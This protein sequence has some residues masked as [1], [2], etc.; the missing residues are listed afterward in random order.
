MEIYLQYIIAFLNTAKYCYPIFFGK[1][2]NSYAYN[3]L[4]FSKLKINSS[5]LSGWHGESNAGCESLN[6]DFDWVYF[7][8]FDP[9]Q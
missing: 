9:L 3:Y 6:I 4:K 1:F 7:Q 8:V 2:L 5:Y